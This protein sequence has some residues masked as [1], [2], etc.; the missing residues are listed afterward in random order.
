MQTVYTNKVKSSRLKKRP[1]RSLRKAF[2][3]GACVCGFHYIGV[4]IDVLGHVVSNVHLR[5]YDEVA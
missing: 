1:K 5:K 4:F 2:D 3:D